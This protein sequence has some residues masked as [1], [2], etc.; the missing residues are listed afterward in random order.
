MAAVDNVNCVLIEHGGAT[1][2]IVLSELRE[3]G[4]IFTIPGSGESFR[5]TAGGERK[6][7]PAPSINKND[8][9]ST[10]FTALSKTATT[11]AHAVPL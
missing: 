10:L 7:Q 9:E 3:R 4:W 8:P 6:L 2:R 1:Y 11:A 5:V